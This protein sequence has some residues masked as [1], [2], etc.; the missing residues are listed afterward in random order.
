[1]LGNAVRTRNKVLDP[2]E[3]AIE[4]GLDHVSIC[5]RL[6]P[7]LLVSF[8][9][10]SGNEKNRRVRV[11]E[12]SGDTKQKH[13]DHGIVS[14]AKTGRSVLFELTTRPG[15]QSLLLWPQSAR[16]SVARLTL[17]ANPRHRRR[18]ETGK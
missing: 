9:G 4:V 16:S 17:G 18:S 3:Q 1:M 10:R 5:S 7:S 6:N 13:R 11:W 14:P 15:R 8:I 12:A 2:S